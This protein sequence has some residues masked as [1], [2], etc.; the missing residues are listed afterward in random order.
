MSGVRLFGSTLLHVI[1][2][3]SITDFISA[4]VSLDFISHIP[5]LLK[6]ALYKDSSGKYGT[7]SGFLCRNRSN[8]QLSL[9]SPL[10]W[11]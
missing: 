11:D 2:I 8:P 7:P 6:L 5:V 10:L 1:K 3:R 9:P 4:E